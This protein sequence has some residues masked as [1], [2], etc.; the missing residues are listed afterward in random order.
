MQGNGVIATYLAPSEALIY[1][2]TYQAFL[3]S[4]QNEL[5]TNPAV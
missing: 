3:E 2:L 5:V 4:Q 1:Y